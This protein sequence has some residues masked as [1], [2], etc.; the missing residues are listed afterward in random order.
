LLSVLIEVGLVIAAAIVVTWAFSHTDNSQ[1]LPGSEEEWLT[2]SAY[3]TSYSLHNYGYV[4]LWQPLF[5]N[6]EPFIDNPF[7]FVLN[8]LSTAPSIFTDGVTGIKISVILTAIVAAVGGWTLGRVL[9]FGLLARLLLALLCLG[10]GNM[11]AMIGTGYFQLGVTQAYFPW[12]IAGFI[13]VLR[14]RRRW[15]LVLTA[16]AFTLM[17]W[18]GNIWY[19]LPMLLMMLL[20]TITH[21]VT[22]QVMGN[23]LR[24]L[25]IKLGID[26]WVMRRAV[27]SGV[28]IVGLAMITFL[29]IWINRD[30]IYGHPD[31]VSAGP[32]IDFGLAVRQFVDNDLNQYSQS[33]PTGLQL[34]FDYSYVLPV[35][36]GVALFIVLP[37][38]RPLWKSGTARGWRVWIVVAF[39]IIF[40]AVWG[41]GGNSIFVY[42]YQVIPLLGQWRF[43]GRALAVASFGIA[44]LVAA[45]VDGLWRALAINPAPYK[46]IR[47]RA[48]I[49]A[50]PAQA[51]IALILIVP[52]VKAAQQVNEQWPLL[53]NVAVP[54][55]RFD[56]E[57]I[58]WLRQQHPYE[59][60][61]VRSQ[62]YYAVG[63]YLKNQVRT[64]YIS[65]D[66]HIIPEPGT[67]YH[68]DLYRMSL[69]P[70]GIAWEDSIRQYLKDNGYTMMQDSPNPV[71]KN[72]CL[73]Y[74][75]DALS[76]AYTI[77]EATLV[78]L[79]Q[80]GAPLTVSNTS[81]ITPAT[82]TR[83]PDRIALSVNG[84][85]DQPLVVTIQERDYPGWAVQV[86]GVP[87]TLESI[88]GQV[89]VVLQPGGTPHTVYFYY[90]PLL[91]FVGG[92]ITLLTGLLCILY[93]LRADRFIPVT[94]KE[95]IA[96]LRQRFFG[97]LRVLAN[98]VR[99]SLRR[100][101]VLLMNP[102]V[103]NP[104]EPG[105]KNS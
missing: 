84:M 63:A 41:A 56:D 24:T 39:I 32:V 96:R 79:D 90:F 9:G 29:P 78:S 89:G 67:L 27:L 54:T 77:P 13:G 7:T 100:F 37:P 23:N 35:W 28:M 91:L 82:L 33:N 6:G 75:P 11:A 4:P 60:L 16:I 71:D 14:F 73:W 86:D 103:F 19:T 74:K 10:K 15:P 25:Q 97:F 8:P 47:E 45:R 81:P 58:T 55:S 52:C 2:S 49:L 21:M 22:F 101:G 17:F 68:G 48:P 83:Y 76:Y 44:V 43:V 64:Y 65:A 93:L 51:L 31:D 102:D 5:E 88:G 85:P 50:L 98:H 53:A 94:V 12:I 42:L 66:F 30:R 3:M 80:S 99:P 105:G 34:Q 18:A 70:Y 69:P 61:T 1:E 36:F 46:W 104:D 38:I 26:R 87:A 20:L 57:C 62:D 59:Q 92:A 72:H 40:A 95:R